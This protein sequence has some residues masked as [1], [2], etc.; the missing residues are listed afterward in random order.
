[1]GKSLAERLLLLPTISVP[2]DG[3][4]PSLCQ[5]GALKRLF[6]YPLVR[7]CDMDSEV[8]EDIVRMVTNACERN[9]NSN[10]KA[11]QTIKQQLDEK[12]GGVWHTVVGEEFG[13]QLG[14]DPQSLLYMFYGGNL[15]ICI[16][17]C[18]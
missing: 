12:Y 13:L 4:Q 16:W 2:S 15:A 17:K 6:T 14:H 3:P 8:R 18:S 5:T 11:A 10:Q 1:M 9:V 7:D